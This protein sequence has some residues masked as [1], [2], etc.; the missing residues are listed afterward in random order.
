[1]TSQL[2]LR[3]TEIEVEDQL[4]MSA[5]ESRIKEMDKMTGGRQNLIVVASLLGC[6]PNLPGLARTCEVKC[7]IQEPRSF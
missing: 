1:M 2:L 7:K 4:L 5:I 6:I 3:L